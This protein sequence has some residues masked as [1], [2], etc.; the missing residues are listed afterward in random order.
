[1]EKNYVVYNDAGEII[2]WG[3]MSEENI[4]LNAEL[5]GKHYLIGFGHP[6]SHRVNLDTLEIVEKDK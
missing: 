4:A 6:L 3:M 2:E 5:T 1:M